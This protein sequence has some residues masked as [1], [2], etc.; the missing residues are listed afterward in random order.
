MVITFESAGHYTVS[1]TDVG[2]IKG[3]AL[4]AERPVVGG[5][6]AA[7]AAAGRSVTSGTTNP[8]I[9]GNR[10]YLEVRSI[11][12]G[13]LMMLVPFDSQWARDN[14]FALINQGIADDDAYMTVNADGTVSDTPVS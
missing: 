10:A 14:A 2:F 9:W 4:T 8:S 5:G 11:A 6:S 3:A 1:S 13:T 12:D 7:E